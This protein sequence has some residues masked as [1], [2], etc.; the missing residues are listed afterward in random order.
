MFRLIPNMLTL[1]NLVAGMTAVLLTVDRDPR[2]AAILVLAGMLLDALDGR[3]ARA[4]R[5][6]SAFGE[7][8]DSLCDV[9]TFGVAPALI[10][11]VVALRGLG[12]AGILGAIAFVSAGVLRLARFHVVK[13]NRTEFVGMPI[14]AAGGLLAALA[15]YHEMI[16]LPFMAIFTFSLSYLMVSKSRYPNFK[17]V[18]PPTVSLLAIPLIVLFAVCIFIFQRSFIPLFLMVVLA[19]Y[20]IFGILHDLRAVYRIFGRFFRRVHREL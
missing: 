14:T 19:G 16:A 18:G 1:A 9:V 8:L 11:Y 10:M 7:Q 20:G 15:L 13:G 12:V 4:L 3:A 5:V 17:H 6:E 2:T